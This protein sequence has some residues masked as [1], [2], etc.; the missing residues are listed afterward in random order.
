[1]RCAMVGYGRMGR[2]IEDVA[3]RRGHDIAAIVDPVTRPGVPMLS[4]EWAET[5]VEVVFEFTTPTSASSNVAALVEAGIPVVC[6]TTGWAPDDRLRS[7]AEERGVAAVIAANLSIGV[8]LLY[9]VVR[10]AARAFGATGLYAPYVWERHHAGKADAPSGTALRLASVIREADPRHPA[11]VA[12]LGGQPLSPNT[13]HVAATR[14]G[15]DPGFHVV[16]FEGEYDSVAI[17]HRARSRE[18]FAQGAVAAAEWLRSAPPGIHGF[19]AV[20]DAWIERAG[21]GSH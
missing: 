14:A 16:G 2:A 9:R 3:R 1:M 15:H 18:G 20:L 11:I 6:G 7:L 4:R 17:E 8:N 13:V 21:G 19:D 12:D 10:E 5:G